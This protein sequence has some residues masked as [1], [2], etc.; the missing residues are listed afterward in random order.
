MPPP[1]VA[2][3]GSTVNVTPGIAAATDSCNTPLAAAEDN[4][5]D[6]DPS[7]EDERPSTVTTTEVAAPFGTT[8]VIK[9]MAAGTLKADAKAFWS[10]MTWNC[11][12]M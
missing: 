9:H 12:S 3:T 5:A 8:S 1:F 10:P 4:A 11:G 2:A 7:C 6:T